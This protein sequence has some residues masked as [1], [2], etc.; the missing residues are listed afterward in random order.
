M[1]IMLPQPSEEAPYFITISRRA[2]FKRLHRRNGCPVSMAQVYDTRDVWKLEAEV[3][4]A[5]CLKC[6]KAAS[7]SFASS[8]DS[9]SSTSSGDSSSD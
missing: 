5:R 8:S 3:A 7:Q 2:G 9:S 1:D 6:F 4:D